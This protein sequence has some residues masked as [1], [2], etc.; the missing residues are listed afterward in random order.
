MTSSQAWQGERYPRNPPRKYLNKTPVF[1]SDPYSFSVTLYNLNYGVDDGNDGGETSEEHR[2]I[3][4]RKSGENRENGAIE[5][6]AT[7]KKILEL[8]ASKP[9]MTAVDLSVQIGIAR[10]NIEGLPVF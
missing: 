7:Q 8:L 10:R 9:N 6:N 4:G 1:R 5:M 2:K 3:I